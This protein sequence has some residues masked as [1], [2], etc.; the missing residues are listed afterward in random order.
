MNRHVLL[1]RDPKSKWTEG[2]RFYIDAGSDNTL[3][4]GETVDAQL[5]VGLAKPKKFRLAVEIY[6]VPQEPVVPANAV[7]VWTGKPRTR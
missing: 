5:V 6:G 7:L 2:A 1:T 3:S 4:P